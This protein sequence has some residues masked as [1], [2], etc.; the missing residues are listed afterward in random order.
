[1]E[2][3]AQRRSSRLRPN[4]AIADPGED[5]DEAEADERT[6]SSCLGTGHPAAVFQ[7]QSAAIGQEEDEL[8]SQGPGS[9]SP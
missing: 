3:T 4:S 1:M 2:V 9:M 6:S 8:R 7:A 5:V